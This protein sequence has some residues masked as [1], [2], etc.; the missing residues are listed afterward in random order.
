MCTHPGAH[1]LKEHGLK[2]LPKRNAELEGDGRPRDGEMVR[3]R[4]ARPGPSGFS[5]KVRV[6]GGVFTFW[7]LLRSVS[8]VLWLRLLK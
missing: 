3:A 8:V 5:L 7:P 2:S 1:A 6:I 4:L